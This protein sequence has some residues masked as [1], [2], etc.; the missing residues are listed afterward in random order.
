MQMPL[1]KS[2]QLAGQLPVPVFRQFA[3]IQ[4]SLQ[5]QPQQQQVFQIDR[6]V[7]RIAA[8]HS[9]SQRS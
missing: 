8:H 5:F 3:G 2:I 7:P 6:G 9:G 4:Q 1:Q